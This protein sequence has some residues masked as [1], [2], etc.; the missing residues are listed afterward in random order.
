[1]KKLLNCPKTLIAVVLVLITVLANR[2]TINGAT[3]K[4]ITKLLFDDNYAQKWNFVPGSI[5]RGDSLKVVKGNEELNIKLCGI[6]AP[7]IEQ[8]LGIESR[9]YL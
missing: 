4:A 1:M 9:D 8:P 2:K 7:E 6:A 3:E 5:D